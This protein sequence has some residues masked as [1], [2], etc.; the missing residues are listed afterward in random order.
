MAY[1]TQQAT[2][3]LSEFI[4]PQLIYDRLHRVSLDE[5]ELKI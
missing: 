5:N 1:I 2:G 4:N 3:E